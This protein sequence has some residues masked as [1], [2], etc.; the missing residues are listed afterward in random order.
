[1]DKAPE[2]K[3]NH[4]GFNEAMQNH[5][6]GSECNYCHRTCVEP[7]QCTNCPLMW[8]AAM[9]KENGERRHRLSCTLTA[10]VEVF[11][12]VQRVAEGGNGF[13]VTT[14][15]PH[16]GITPYRHGQVPTPHRGQTVI[17]KVQTNE[18]DCD[19]NQ[20]L[21]L[22]DE[23]RT[24]QGA[25]HCPQLWYLIMRRGKG[26]LGRIGWTSKKVFLNTRIK[27]TDG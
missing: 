4:L 11:V 6:S 10:V 1:M 3:D 13:I 14:L 7:L 15:T 24:I 22:Y 25:V 9:C 19:E 18:N 17:V 5:P 12:K 23:S 8:C 16:F 27:A 26:V 21:G 20:Y 2:M